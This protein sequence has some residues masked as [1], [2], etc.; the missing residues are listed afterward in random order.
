MVQ[1]FSLLQFYDYDFLTTSLAYLNR[2]PNPYAPHV[3]SSD[4]LESYVDSEGRLR[5]TR[6]VVKRGAL[7]DF[8]KPF[9]GKNLDSWVIEKLIIDP[10]TEKIYAYSANVDHRRF[11]KVQEFLTYECCGGLTNLQLRVRFLSNFYGLKERIEQWSR[12]KFSHNMLN[13]RLGFV[14]AINKLK[15]RSEMSL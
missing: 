7:P 8:I 5:T 6:L 4:T 12:D 9:L 15:G 2:Y 10:T 3:L 1:L 14:Y 13:L 11:I